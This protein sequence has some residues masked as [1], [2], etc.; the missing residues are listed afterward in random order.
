MI[1]STLLFSG[2]DDQ[3]PKEKSR[4]ISGVLDQAEQIDLKEQKVK[5]PVTRKV[6]LSAGHRIE[7][8]KKAVVAS[9]INLIKSKVH[10]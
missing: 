7:R 2:C 4:E 5:K 8:Y 6:S 1:A 10:R 3:L 9:E